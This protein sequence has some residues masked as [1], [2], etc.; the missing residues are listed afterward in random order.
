MIILILST[1][2]DEQQRFSHHAQL[3]VLIVFV[4]KY[5]HVT[6]ER[7]MS[8]QIR[9]TGHT[10]VHAHDKYVHAHSHILMHPFAFR[11]LC[12]VRG[13][14]QPW[15]KSF[16]LP[17]LLTLLA[18][19][20][21]PGTH[22]SVVQQYSKNTAPAGSV[23]VAFEDRVNQRTGGMLKVVAEVHTSRRNVCVYM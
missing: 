19:L 22:G 4:Q 10:R 13:G 8:V 7:E 15:K 3:Q 9:D 1:C 21:A 23:G 20:S 5:V 18:F 14:R 2:T 6:C 17:M 11:T 12:L 16:P